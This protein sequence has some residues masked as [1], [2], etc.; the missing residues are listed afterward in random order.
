MLIKKLALCVFREC[1]R[2]EQALVQ[3]LVAAI[4]P[5]YLTATRNRVTNS[6]TLP[7]SEVLQYLQVT[8]GRITAQML[9]EK[10]DAVNRMTYNVNLPIDIICNAIEDLID[11]AELANDPITPNQAINKAYLL[12]IKTNRFKEATREWNRRP[13]A[14]RGWPQL[15]I[16]FRQAHQELRETTDL[17]IEQA[18]LQQQQANLVEQVVA[19]IQDALSQQ[20]LITA[21]APAPDPVQEV[22]AQIMAVQAANAASQQTLTAFQQQL[23]QMQTMMHQMQQSM[24]AN[25]HSGH[26]GSGGRNRHGDTTKY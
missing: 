10:H 20:S 8:Y 11:F 16:F 25:R 3:Q 17:T 9:K 4:E 5:Q 1:I 26:G 22:I 7:I 18:Q 23:Q 13:V 15:K 12:L 14:E 24:G 6:I 21:P 2:V 19:G